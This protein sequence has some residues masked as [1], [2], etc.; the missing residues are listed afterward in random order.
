MCSLTQLMAIHRLP[1]LLDFIYLFI[2]GM[3]HVILFYFLTLQ[4]CIGFAIYQH[5]SS[6]GKHVFP[7][8][9]FNTFQSMFSAIFLPVSNNSKDIWLN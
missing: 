9:N 2:G 6:T 3:F 4:Y 8:L 7:I 1:I 5:E